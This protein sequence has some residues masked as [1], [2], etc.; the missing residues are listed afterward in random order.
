CAFSRVGDWGEWS[1]CLRNGQSCGF[2]RGRQTRTR[3]LSWKA[4]DEN[5]LLCPAQSD[6]REC[7]MRKRC[8]EDKRRKKERETADERLKKVE[9]PE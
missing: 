9:T 3:I 8:P 5:T 4:P 7:R 1:F 2:K 6:S